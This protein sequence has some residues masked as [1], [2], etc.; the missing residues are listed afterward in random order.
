MY[1]IIKFFTGL[2]P[3][4]IQN[5]IRCTRSRIFY[6]LI[7]FF[8]KIKGKYL[9]PPHEVKQKIIHDYRKKFN[10]N[11]LVETGTYRGDMVYAQRRFFKKIISVELSETLWQ[12]AVKRFKKNNKIKL[13][14]GDSGKLMSEIMKEIDQ[15][16][17]FW[18][19]GHYCAGISTKGNTECPIYDELDAIFKAK[20]FNH[21]LLIDDAR[22]FIGKNDYPT[23]DELSEYVRK[24]NPA[25]EFEV[26][27]DIIRILH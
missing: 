12:K 27:D 25:S 19:D 1:K 7:I 3:E 15:P 24:N 21:V 16:A 26:K 5:W 9:P 23:I 18:L 14:Q 8:W 10:Y 11:I 17:I 6:N 2:F 13:F 4:N 22:C 20:K